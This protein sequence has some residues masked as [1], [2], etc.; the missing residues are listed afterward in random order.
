MVSKEALDTICLECQRSKG[1]IQVACPF[2]TISNDYCDEY[3][4]IKKDLDILED[5]IKLFEGED[6]DGWIEFNFNYT[7]EPEDSIDNYNGYVSLLKR[8]R[9]YLEELENGSNKD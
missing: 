5:F 9:N 7:R 2:R 4:Q 6:L 8:I 3:E 1:K